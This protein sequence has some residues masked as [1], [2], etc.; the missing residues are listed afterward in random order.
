MRKVF[1][2][3]IKQL[4]GGGTTVKFKFT[5]VISTILFLVGCS[6]GSSTSGVTKEA[7]QYSLAEVEQVVASEPTTSVGIHSNATTSDDQTRAYY[8]PCKIKWVY[9]FSEK[10]YLRLIP[11]TSCAW[12]WAYVTGS[13]W[14]VQAAAVGTTAKANNMYVYLYRTGTSTWS[15]VVL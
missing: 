8:M 15:W 12:S 13:S 9:M 7:P 14:R 1:G 4:L 6:Q 11:T 2:V 10:T 5:L 3:V